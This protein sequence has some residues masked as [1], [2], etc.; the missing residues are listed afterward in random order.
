MS[1]QLISVCLLAFTFTIS[2]PVRPAAGQI[3]V[4][5]GEACGTYRDVQDLEERAMAQPDDPVGFLRVG[6]Y[7][8]DT[9]W[10]RA[11]RLPAG[12]QRDLITRGIGALD[13]ALAL[14]PE[15]HDALVYKSLLFRL[16]ATLEGDPHRQRTLMDEA[17]ALGCERPCDVTVPNG[18]GTFLAPPSPELHG[19][20]LLQSAI[21]GSPLGTVVFKL[22]GSG[23]TGADG[24]LR[25]N[26]VP[27]ARNS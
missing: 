9:V 23:F 27:C 16:Q 3:Y 10:G 24:S 25:M 4:C 19:N 26:G 1:R 22:G 14:R 6:S 13:R 8:F 18:R 11:W 17:D 20:R 21:G 5:D 12:R 15:Y 7:Y 2:L